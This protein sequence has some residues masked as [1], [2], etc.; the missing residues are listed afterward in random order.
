MTTY[1]QDAKRYWNDEWKGK[2]RWP[3]TSFAKEAYSV[4]AKEGLKEILDLGCG[5]G[6]DALYFADKDLKVTAV[7][8]SEGGISILREENGENIDCICKDVRDI[9]FPDSSFDVVYAHLILQY[10]DHAEMNIIMKKLYKMLKKNGYIFIKCKSV[11]DPLYGIGEKLEDNV[12]MNEHMRHFFTK[13]YMRE[14]LKDFQVL[15]V[16]ELS[17]KDQTVGYK[18]KAAFIEGIAKK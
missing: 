2:G 11:K 18:Y 1:S 10:L 17:L 16:K 15:G 4:I 14:A 6:R 13:K 8:I 9:D 7:D 12:Y 5:A 3:V